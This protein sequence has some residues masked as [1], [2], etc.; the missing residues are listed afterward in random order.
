M[1]NRPAAQHEVARTT[2]ER[3][4]GMR[5]AGRM[6]GRSGAPCAAARRRAVRDRRPVELRCLE[7]PVGSSDRRR[8]PSV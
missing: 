8:T 1:Q 2:P 7:V 6:A 4:G 5:G 3:R